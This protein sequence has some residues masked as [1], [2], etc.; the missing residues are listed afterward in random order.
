MRDDSLGFFWE[1]KPVE[2]VAKV[3]AKS[4][5]NKSDED[6]A[7]WLENEG[8]VILAGKE[9]KVEVIDPSEAV[10]TAVANVEHVPNADAGTVTEK[11]NK[12]PVVTPS[13]KGTR[14]EGFTISFKN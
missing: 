14:E 9:K 13:G 4:I 5:R 11:K 10:K 1:D 8:E 12:V 2:K 6:Y 7:S 3:V